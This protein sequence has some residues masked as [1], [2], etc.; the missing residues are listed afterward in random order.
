LEPQQGTLVEMLALIAHFDGVFKFHLDRYK[1]PNRYPG[2][3]AHLQRAEAAKELF[4]LNDR[5]ALTDHLYGTSAALADMAIAPFIRQFAATD[6][7]WFDAQPWPHL[8]QWLQR[9]NGSGLFRAVMQSCPVWK[10]GAP[11]VCFPAMT[12]AAALI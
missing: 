6:T 11:G 8:Q 2:V 12:V 9:F 7:V 1:Y 3:D 4:V 5:L 10:A